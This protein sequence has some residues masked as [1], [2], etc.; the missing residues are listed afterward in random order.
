MRP[1][2]VRFSH[3]YRSA[4][5]RSGFVSAPMAKKAAPKVTLVE[6]QALQTPTASNVVR[7]A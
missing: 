2:S 7:A 6:Q 5:R 3:T 1:T 4:S